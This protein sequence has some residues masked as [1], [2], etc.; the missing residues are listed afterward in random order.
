MSNTIRH[1]VAVMISDLHLGDYKNAQLEDFDRDDDFERLL[2]EVI[3][4]RAGGPAT[5]IIAGD[6]IDFP[7]VFP[8]LAIHT[9]GPR[10]GVCEEHSIQKM[11]R[12]IEGHGK[13]FDAL[14]TFMSEKG[15]QVLILPGNHDVDLHWGGV[16]EQLRAAIGNPSDESYQFISAGYLR[17]RDIYIEHGNQYSYDNSV[18][19]WGNPIIDAEDGKRLER[20][21]GTFFMDTVYNDL[22]K[23]DSFINKVYPHAELA[24]IALRSFRDD[25]NVSVKLIARLVAFFVTDGKRFLLERLLGGESSS[26]DV[27]ADPE[28]VL[29][30]VGPWSNQARLDEIIAETREL[31]GPVA[32]PTAE[33]AAAGK[34]GG[35]LLGRTTERGL[36]KR[37]NELLE[38]GITIVAFGH[39]HDEID[40]NQRPKWGTGDPRRVFNTGSWMPRIPIG[41]KEKPRWKDLADREWSHNIHYLL[42]RF[43]DPVRAELEPL[44]RPG[45]SA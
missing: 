33:A 39:T 6:F 10:V 3:P 27:S 43:G 1:P 37:A 24:R 35:G 40:G 4:E 29:L 14:D 20:P 12:V 5:L 42:I 41:A 45:G 32:P 28:S 18:E 38:E 44:L 16:Q 7:Q 15:G 9:L 19:N 34:A 25:K 21:W 13:V 26:T 11:Q 22:E 2:L 17:E 23:R 30:E 36:R 8:G 31:V